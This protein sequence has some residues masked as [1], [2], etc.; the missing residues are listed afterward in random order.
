[1]SVCLSKVGKASSCVWFFGG[2]LARRCSCLSILLDWI[3]ELD[4]PLGMW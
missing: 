1:M 4:Y 3:E 2:C